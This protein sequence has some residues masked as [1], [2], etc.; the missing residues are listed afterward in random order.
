MEESTSTP[1][2]FGARSIDDSSET[3]LRN[4]LEI[5]RQRHDLSILSGVAPVKTDISDLAY[6]Y[7]TG[8]TVDENHPNFELVYDMLMGIRV[9][10]L[11]YFSHRSPAAKPNLFVLYHQGIL[12]LFNV[13]NSVPQAV[14]LHLSQS[15]SFNSK[16]I[17][18]GFFAA[19]VTFSTLTL[20]NTL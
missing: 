6:N 16:I 17:P 11:I 2:F 19:Y 9:S 18:L 12:G 8:S 15:T 5:P 4:N 14:I 10:V 20:V 1:T 7:Q 13:L 3:T